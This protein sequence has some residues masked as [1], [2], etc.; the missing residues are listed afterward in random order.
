M[1]PKL[2]WGRTSK[3]VPVKVKKVTIS[4]PWRSDWQSDG[5]RAFAIRSLILTHPNW[6]A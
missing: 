3:G 4:S 1:L 2:V 6:I 5:G